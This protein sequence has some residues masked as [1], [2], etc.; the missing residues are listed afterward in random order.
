MGSAA[1]S[2]GPCPK[3]VEL[4]TLLDQVMPARPRKGLSVAEESAA[5]QGMLP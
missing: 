3:R 1:K 4:C 2:L 5:C